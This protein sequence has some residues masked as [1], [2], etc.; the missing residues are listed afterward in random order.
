MHTTKPRILYVDDHADSCFVVKLWLEKIGYSVVT[1]DSVK[2]GLQ[3]AQDEAFDL[4]L[5]D[6]ALPDG[7]GRDLCERIREFD[8]ATPVIFYSAH[9]YESDKQ[10]ALAC[11][12]QGYVAK[13]DIE[14]LPAA[15]ARTIQAS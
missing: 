12:A 10:E 5:L 4:Y 3:L 14:A 9:A 8:S 15:I 7:T 6:I 11:G 2:S 13:P 1:A